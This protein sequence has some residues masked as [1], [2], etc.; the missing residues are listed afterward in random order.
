MK[1]FIYMQTIVQFRQEVNEDGTLGKPEIMKSWVSPIKGAQQ[2]Y[3]KKNDKKVVEQ[4]K[5]KK[6]AE[7]LASLQ[8]KVGEVEYQ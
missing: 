2:T 1:E 6:E 5:K 7:L 8:T 4:V 3:T